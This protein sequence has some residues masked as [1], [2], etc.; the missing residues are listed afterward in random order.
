MDLF[1]KRVATED[2]IADLPSR[3]VRP[4][5]VWCFIR[6]F[7]LPGQDFELMN[8]LGMTFVEP[9]L[10]ELYEDAAAWEALQERWQLH[11]SAHPQPLLRALLS[12]VCIAFFPQKSNRKSP[13]G[14]PRR[15][16]AHVSPPVWLLA[17][18]CAYNTASRAMLTILLGFALGV[19]FV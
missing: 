8:Q 7:S 6:L 2:N 9:V 12:R 14:A 16:R 13:S 18:C 15:V 10:A 19:P 17:L 1:I 3:K 4:L 5:A 11:W